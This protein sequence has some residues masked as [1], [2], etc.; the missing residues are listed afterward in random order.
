MEAAEETLLGN[1][2]RPPGL[3]ESP[4]L[5]ELPVSKTPSA[6]NPRPR[7]ELGHRI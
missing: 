3:Q 2:G 4:A 7:K 5:R 1:P 6:R